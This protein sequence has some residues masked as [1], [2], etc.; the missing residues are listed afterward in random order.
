MSDSEESRAQAKYA[1]N[2]YTSDPL[3]DNEDE[4][5]N[6]ADLIAD[7]LLYALHELDEDM[8]SLVERALR[9]AEADHHLACLQRGEI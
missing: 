5:T 3:F 2:A 1:L 8:E 7:L 6:V 9:N 4:A